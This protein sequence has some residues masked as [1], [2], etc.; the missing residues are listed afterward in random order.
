[1]NDGVTVAASSVGDLDV[2]LSPGIANR[3]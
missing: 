3:L 1:M 2:G